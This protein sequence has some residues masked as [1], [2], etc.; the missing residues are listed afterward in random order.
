MRSTTRH[1][2]DEYAAGGEVIVA[3]Q[4][5]EPDPRSTTGARR[6]SKA[7]SPTTPGHRPVLDSGSQARHRR[8]R[9]AASRPSA[10]DAFR[11]DIPLGGGVGDTHFGGEALARRGSAGGRRLG[12]RPELLSPQR[13]IGR[14][15]R[16]SPGDGPSRRQGDRFPRPAQVAPGRVDP[17]WRGPGLPRAPPASGAQ[18][19]T[20]HHGRRGRRG[21]GAH[22]DAKLVVLVSPSYCGVA[23][24]LAGIAAVAHARRRPVYVDEA[25]GPHFHFHPALPPSAMASGVDGAVVV[26]PQGARRSDPGRDPAT[27]SGDSSTPTACGP[28]SAWCRRP[29]HPC[30]SWRRST[31]PG[32][33]WRCMARR[34]S[35]GPSRWPRTRGPAQALPGVE[36]LDAE[37]LGVDAFDLTKLVIDVDGLGITGYEAEDALRNRFGVGPEMSDLVGVVCLVTIGDTEASID[38]LVDAFATL[39]REHYRGAGTT[40]RSPL[41]RCRRCRRGAGDVAARG[42]FRAV[43]RCSARRRR[44]ARS[45]PSW[46]SPTRP[47]S[48]SSR[49]AK[50]SPTTRSPICA[51]ASAHG[52]YSPAP[53]TPR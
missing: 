12:R 42:I 23:S 26:D 35:S 50:S 34:C 30:S 19:R 31:P 46:S 40:R 43:S 25:W 11:S 9:G 14:Q 7:F 22:P 38:R 1:G 28:R 51:K 20:R 37:Q 13:L 48:R 5:N 32:G 6:C 36:V 10:S 33:R 17:H 2:P 27:C 4:D 18:R 15:P 16:L 47:A 3:G 29:V 41:V 53:P 21:A 44:A 45:R 24:D 8:G 49:P 52:M 39:S